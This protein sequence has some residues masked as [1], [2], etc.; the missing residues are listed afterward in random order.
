M[1]NYYQ[2]A[3]SDA[4]ETVREYQ[5]TILEQLE[6]KGEASDDLYND[7]GNGDSYHHE[8]HVDKWYNL[9]EAAELLDELSAYEETDTGLWEGQ[10]PRRAIGTQAAYTYGIAVYTFWSDLIKEIND[11]AETIIEDFDNQ[12]SDA[13]KAIEKAEEA[14]DVYTG[15]TPDDLQTEKVAA[16][17]AMI[18]ETIK[19]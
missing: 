13:E 5:D 1:S 14:E 18:G 9:T 19:E 17:E 16:L 3:E 11:E 8:C 2:E 4:R 12:I 15:P 10:E 6:D 7:Y